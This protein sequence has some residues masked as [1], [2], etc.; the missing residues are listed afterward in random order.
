M[1]LSPK[2]P[3]GTQSSKGPLV[4]ATLRCPILQ[5]GKLRPRGLETEANVTPIVGASHGLKPGLLKASRGYCLTLCP[6]HPSSGHLSSP[7]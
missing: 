2:Q 5:M 4:T 1:T 3:E 6:E 7:E